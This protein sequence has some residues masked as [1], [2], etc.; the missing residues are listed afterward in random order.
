[1]ADLVQNLF[2]SPMVG[3]QIQSISLNASSVG[4]NTVV[5]AVPNQRIVVLKYKRISSASVAVTWESDG[6][7]VLD[8]PCTLAA[9]G[10]EAEA[11]C[12]SG[13]FSTLKGEGLILVLGGAAQVGGNLLYVVLP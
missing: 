7:T 8:G 9:N 3:G 10:G 2:G 12:A 5:A 1:M 4:A 13:H 11:F 6:G